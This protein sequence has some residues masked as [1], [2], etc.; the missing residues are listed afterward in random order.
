MFLKLKKKT[1]TENL[2]TKENAF[3]FPIRIFVGIEATNTK[4]DALFQLA[5]NTDLVS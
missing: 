4:I 3:G 2:K 1:K 5:Q